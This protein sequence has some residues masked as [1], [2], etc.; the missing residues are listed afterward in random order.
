MLLLLVCQAALS[1]GFVNLNFERAKIVPDPASPYYPYGIAITNALP[2]WFCDGT[3]QGDITYNAQATGSSAIT[4]WATNGQQ[5]S[6]NYSVYLQGGLGPGVSISQTGLVPVSSLSLLFEAQP[7][8]DATSGSLVISLG[9]NNLPYFAISNTANYTLYGADVSAY[10]GQTAQFKISA[11]SGYFNNWNIDNF[12]FSTSYVPEPGVLGS[13]ALSG[14][15]LA[16][17]RRKARTD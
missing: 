3:Q 8:R 4:L 12:Q 1:Q 16:F 15:L 13:S 5:I 17:R 14:L 11:L 10:A 9:G 6:G 2:G 7:D